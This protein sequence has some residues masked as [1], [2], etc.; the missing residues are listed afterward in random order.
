MNAND[1]KPGDVVLT[2]VTIE[3][4][5][6]NV[7]RV[8]TVNDRVEKPDVSFWLYVDEVEPIQPP[9]PAGRVLKYS[10]GDEVI[11]RDCPKLGVGKIVR[12]HDGTSTYDVEINNKAEFYRLNNDLHADYS[13]EWEF[14][15]SV[16]INSRWC[17][18]HAEEYLL[19][20]RRKGGE[21]WKAIKGLIN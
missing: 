5:D 20:A 12:P 6:G 19:L 17:R 8:H 16:S 3:E 7:I 21:G 9:Q 14:N 18:L 2:K 4:V 10:V 1:L 15:P 13:V 11:H